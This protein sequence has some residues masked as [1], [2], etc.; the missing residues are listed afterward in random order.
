M[1]SGEAKIH[2]V[3]CR[4]PV[5]SVG[6]CALIFA[7]ML[8]CSDLLVGKLRKQAESDGFKDPNDM[9]KQAKARLLAVK[10]FL[11]VTMG[12]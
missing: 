11:C 6:D 10:I 2:K 1:P 5:A 12:W 7:C 8:S 9:V 4:S 3:S